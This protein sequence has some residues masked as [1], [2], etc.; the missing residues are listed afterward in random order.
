MASDI[1]LDFVE[2]F[3]LFEKPKSNPKK[4]HALNVEFE[5]NP[6]LEQSYDSSE[7]LSFDTSIDFTEEFD[8]SPNQKKL[9]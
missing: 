2:E 8:T 4:L 7:S 3:E 9:L 6:K 5:A 1:S